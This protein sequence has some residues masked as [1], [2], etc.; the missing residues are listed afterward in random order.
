LIDGFIQS[1]FEKLDRR[2]KPLSRVGLEK[3][4]RSVLADFFDVDVKRLPG[5]YKAIA[6]IIGASLNNGSEMILWQTKAHRLFEVAQQSLSDSMGR[7]RVTSYG[8]LIRHG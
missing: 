1:L 2:K 8:V 7:L 5:S 4:L 6:F 3:F